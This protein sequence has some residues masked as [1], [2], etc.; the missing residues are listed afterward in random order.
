M[1]MI[2]PFMHGAAQWAAYNA[3]TMGGR[4]VIPDDVE[5]LRQLQATLQSGAWQVVSFHAKR[6]R[7]EMAAWLV[8]HRVRS[9][10]ALQDFDGAG[11]RY[12]AAESRPDVPVFRR[13]APVVG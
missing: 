8:Q 3:I 1:L 6:A 4:L 7:G 13:H 2:P 5:R 12:V 11:Y 9:V 10:R